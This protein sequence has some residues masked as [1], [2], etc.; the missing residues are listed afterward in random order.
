MDSELKHRP[1]T[2]KLLEQ[3]MG[4]T[5]RHWLGNDCFGNDTTSTGNKRKKISKWDYIKIKAFT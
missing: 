2:V 5:L 3:N 4:K 1:E